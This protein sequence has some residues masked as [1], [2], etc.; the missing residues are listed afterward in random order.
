MVKTASWKQ[1]HV[2]NL[3]DEDFYVYIFW[4]LYPEYV[5]YYQ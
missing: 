4:M 5:I 1:G 2:K 3:H